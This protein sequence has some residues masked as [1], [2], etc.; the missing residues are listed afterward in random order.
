MENRQSQNVPDVRQSHKVY[1]EYHEKLESGIDSRRK[2]L[3]R[4]ENPGDIYQGDA[5]SPLLFVIAMMALNDIL[6]KYTGGYKLIKVTEKNIHF[7]YM[8]GH[9]TVCQKRERIGNPNTNDKK[10]TVS[11]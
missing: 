3:S 2:N 1:R 10:Y 5:L 6:R 4:G 7:I 8:E 9:E 11:I